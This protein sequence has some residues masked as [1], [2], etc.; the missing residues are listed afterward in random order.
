MSEAIARVL[1]SAWADEIAAIDA[2]RT[3]DELLPILMAG[4]VR[5]SEDLAVA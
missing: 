1:E 5:V 2:S 4:K 3:R